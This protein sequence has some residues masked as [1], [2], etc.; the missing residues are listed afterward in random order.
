[1]AAQDTWFAA[2]V[3]AINDLKSSF[4]YANQGPTTS[5]VIRAI[6]SSATSVPLALR[7][8][9]RRGM[10]LVNTDAN[11]L[12]L[13]YGDT[14]TVSSLGWTYIIGPNGTW[15]MPVPVYSGRIDGIWAAAG[16]GV[17]EI[18]EY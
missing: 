15:E 9:T 5:P 16:S 4:D 6:T 10:I 3:Q 1:M 13:R 7:N 11:S 18:T 12:Y 17:A 14:A 2:I 8:P